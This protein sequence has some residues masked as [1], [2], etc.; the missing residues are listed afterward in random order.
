[1]MLSLPVGYRAL[2][3]GAS[4]TIGAE[5][6]A[7]LSADPRCGEVV[8]LHRHSLPAIDMQ[9]EQCIAAAALEL[10]GGNPFHLII[11]AVGLLHDGELIP[12]KK[13]SDLQSDHLIK[14]FAVNAI[15]PALVMRYFA[16]LLH[17]EGSRMIFLSA[18]VGSIGD[19]RLG[20]W[21]GYRASKAALNML[22]KTASIELKR[23]KSRAIVIAMH[24][25]TVNSKLSKPFGGE[26]KG[27]P[28]SLACHEMLQT[29]DG[30][31]SEQS[32]QFL[33]YS[34]EQLPW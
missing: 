24:P 1:M 2:V 28:A 9:D 8:K 32:G 16:P 12:E 31:R 33:S 20:G 3:I 10:S 34:A 25:G 19:N 5:F 22:V 30:L 15:G 29:I 26:T 27:R 11:H 23:T 21:Y 6:A 14:N 7:L 18:K 17:N 4:G 13:L